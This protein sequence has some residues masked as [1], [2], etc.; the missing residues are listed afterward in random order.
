MTIIEDF[1]KKNLYILY[2]Y[3]S[4][5]NVILITLLFILLFQTTSLCVCQVKQKST[6]I[7]IASQLN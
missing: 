3:S 5:A 7:S 2:F 4:F 1:A 6:Q